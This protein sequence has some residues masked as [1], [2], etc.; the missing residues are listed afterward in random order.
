DLEGV[1]IRSLRGIRGM[2]LPNGWLGGAL[3]PSTRKAPSSSATRRACS[4]LFVTWMVTVSSLA[5]R[6][7]QVMTQRQ[8]SRALP[9]RPLHPDSSPQPPA[10][11]FLSSRH[12][13]VIWRLSWWLG[14]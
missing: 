6:R 4:I 11:P 1:A 10:T 3:P 9:R 12:A 8:P 2:C 14:S 5:M 13:R 7:L